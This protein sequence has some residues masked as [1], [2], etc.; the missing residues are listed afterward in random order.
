MLPEV[1]YAVINVESGDVCGR[2]K[3]ES[4]GGKKM[5]MKE[6][7]CAK[8]RLFR[9]NPVILTFFTG[10]VLFT[11]YCVVWHDLLMAKSLKSSSF[12]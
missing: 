9:A 12:Q 8:A 3:K 2:E 11:S 10:C 4:E 6:L 5:L 1:R 7:H